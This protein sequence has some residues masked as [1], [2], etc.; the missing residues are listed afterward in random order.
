M[1]H[2]ECSEVSH[3]VGRCLV[4]YM[5]GSKED[6]STIT[7]MPEDSNTVLRVYCVVIECLDVMRCYRTALEVWCQN[8][9]LLKY[10][11]S[12]V[13]YFGRPQ[14]VDN[15]RSPASHCRLP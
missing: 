12:F 10:L 13:V 6:V 7:Q 9:T 4:I 14:D 11:T 2:A 1:V 8:L 5:L 15:N 3:E